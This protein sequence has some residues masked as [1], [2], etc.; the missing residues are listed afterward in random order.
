MEIRHS[1]GARQVGS[2][3]K[4]LEMSLPPRTHAKVQRD[5]QLSKAAHHMCTVRHM[6]PFHTI[7][8]EEKEKLKR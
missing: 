5:N 7:M 8:T 6:C 3:G 1:D 4:D 2:V